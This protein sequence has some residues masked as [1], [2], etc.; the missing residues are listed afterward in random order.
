VWLGKACEALVQTSKIDF[1]VRTVRTFP[2]I[3]LRESSAGACDA[4]HNLQTITSFQPALVKFV[5]RALSFCG[6]DR[7]A[8]DAAGVE[9]VARNFLCVTQR[10]LLV[11]VLALLVDSFRSEVAHIHGVSKH[12]WAGVVG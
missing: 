5:V 12:A 10:L 3:L 9:A 11:L 7:V 4:T 2:V 6:L 8:C 1:G